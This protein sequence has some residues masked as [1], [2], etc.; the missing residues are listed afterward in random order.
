MKTYRLLILFVLLALAACGP[1]NP[2]KP[3][4]PTAIMLTHRHN[5]ESRLPVGQGGRRLL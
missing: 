2:D 3:V 1:D 5:L 4:A